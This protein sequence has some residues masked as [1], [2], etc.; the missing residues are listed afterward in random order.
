MSLPKSAPAGNTAHP[1]VPLHRYVLSLLCGEQAILD[2]LPTLSPS[3]A[4]P[5]VP[6]LQERPGGQ[7]RRLLA[8]DPALSVTVEL[9][10]A[11]DGRPQQV[12]H[13]ETLTTQHLAQLLPRTEDD[14]SGYDAD[15]PP[16]PLTR[17]E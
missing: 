3:D 12:F 17:G 6:N 16:T 11:A 10:D 15:A 7:P 8:G 14:P 1:I 9:A 13:A 2:Y 4:V 5:L